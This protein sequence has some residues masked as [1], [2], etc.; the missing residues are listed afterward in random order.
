M[1]KLTIDG[2]EV[3]VPKGTRVIEAAKQL[4]IDIPF[5][6]YHPGLSIAGNCRMCL[7]EIEKTP[8]LQ[9][10]C[11]MECADG[12]VVRTDTEKV[13]QTR[14]HVL[15]FLLVN[16][17]LD[18]PVCDQ[19]G[20]CWL[21]D[22]YMNYGAYGSRVNED[23]LRKPKAV[24]IGPHVMLDAER[25]ILCSRCVRFCDEVSKTSELGIINRGDH[26]EITVFPGNEIDN[27]YSGNVVDICPVGALTD[28]DF[29]F[30]MRVW[31]LDTKK[32]ICSGCARGCNI[33]VQYR[34]TPRPHH[35]KD[36]RVMRLKPRY[37]ESINKWWMCDE[38]RYGY[39][40]V[41]QNRILAPALRGKGTFKEISWEEMLPETAAKLRSA[42]SRAGVLI[43]PQ[44]SNEEIFLATRLFQDELKF[45]HVQLVKPKPDGYQDD[46][47]VRADKSPNSKG[48][49]WQGLTYQE[50]ALKDFMAECGEGFIDGIVVFGQDLFSIPGLNFKQEM[51]QKLKW[52]IYIGSNHNLI[53]EYATHV[54]PAATYMEKDG[55]FTNFEGR[56]QKFE[57]V[58]NPIGESRPEWR[59]LAQLG[60]ELG[61]DFKYERAEDIFREIA[62]KLDP[63]RGMDYKT[64]GAGAE[65]VRVFSA[66][67]VPDLVQ[68]AG[69]IFYNDSV[70]SNEKSKTK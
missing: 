25:C 49:E 19:A 58:L 48:A 55:T 26:A 33:D 68:H 11:H 5:Y 70:Y 52:I 61:V 7:V 22:Y 36:E 23:K 43:S 16:H 9:I 60:R 67:M 21:Q 32:S 14:K 54:I 53:S 13:K 12:M 38:G 30:K 3:E 64:L 59:I 4:G 41:D 15:E 66:P 27:I 37:N 18:C 10:S 31:Y 56:V 44:L 65:D 45:K 47:L 63:F 24:P 51:L 69:L 17:P 28:R 50:Q 40:Y 8:K 6:C 42:G 46:F 1:P 2:K 34:G 62:A 29:R 39:K 35:A 20:E 57:N